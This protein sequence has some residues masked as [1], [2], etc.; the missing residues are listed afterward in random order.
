[1]L[2][3]P[4]ERQGLDLAGGDDEGDSPSAFDHRQHQCAAVR[5]SGDDLLRREGRD[6]W[7]DVMGTIQPQQRRGDVVQFILDYLALASREGARCA[8]LHRITAMAKPAAQHVASF[9]RSQHLFAGCGL[10][11]GRPTA[12]G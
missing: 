3:E 8:V 10:V 9:L 5:R 11:Q 1:M 7:H 4:L 2:V 6:L 12:G